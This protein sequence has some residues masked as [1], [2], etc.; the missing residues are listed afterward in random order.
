MRFLAILAA[1][2]VGTAAAPVA[3]CLE[4][5]LVCPSEQSFGYRLILMNGQ[6]ANCDRAVIRSQSTS[7]IHLIIPAC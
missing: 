3:P 7:S 1:L 4:N 5:A 2:A 6:Q